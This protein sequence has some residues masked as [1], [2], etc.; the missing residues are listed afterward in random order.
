MQLETER[1]FLRDI[2]ESDFEALH[3][4][5]SDPQ[6]VRFMPWG[7]NTEQDTREFIRKQSAAQKENPRTE[8]TLAL[9]P[10]AE[11]R[12]IGTCS[13]RIASPVHNQAEIGYATNRKYWNL[14]YVTEAVRRIIRFGFE[15]LGMHRIFATC[16]PENTG[17]YR[18]MEKNGMQREGLLREN[19]QIHGRWRNSYLYSILEEEYRQMEGADGSQG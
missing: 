12:L 10:K 13:I 6:V 9:V 5:G 4:Y 19:M 8:Y 1:L 2:L 15:E 7:P 17:S 14:G 18:V 16:D 3:E 11:K